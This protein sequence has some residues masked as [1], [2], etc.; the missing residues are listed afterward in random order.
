MV[1]RNDAF[2][3][4]YILASRPYGTLYISVT[5]SLLSRVV[6]HRDEVFKGFTSK[7]GVK[8]LVWYEQHDL[9]TAAIQREKSL[10]RWP[11]DWKINLIER[12]NP[13]W[14]DLFDQMMRGTPGPPKLADWPPP[15]PTHPSS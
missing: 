14:D 1:S 5:S 11:R 6:D 8:R 10:K 7:Y 4:T 13:H 2:I 15:S 3:A 9:M 12:D